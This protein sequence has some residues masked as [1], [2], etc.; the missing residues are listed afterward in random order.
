MMAT[1]TFTR[2]TSARRQVVD[3]TADVSGIVRGTGA[4]AGICLISVPHCSCAVY[5][6]ENEAG[7]VDD[8]LTL[9]ARIVRGG[10]WQHDRIDNNASAHLTAI[11]AGNSV[12]LP[13]E[14]GEVHLGTWQSIMLAE[15]DG[16]RERR[17]NV[18]VM[19]D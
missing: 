4:S 14:G 7:L 1:H 12:A 9:L 15:L 8:V 5:V 2:R 18:T 10:E 6:N 17:V 19:G 13:I 11:L 16:P 3:I